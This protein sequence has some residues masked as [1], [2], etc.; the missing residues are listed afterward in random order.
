M[1]V[2]IYP[3]EVGITWTKGKQTRP[4]QR[5]VLNPAVT[6]PR[7]ILGTLGSELILSSVIMAGGEARRRVRG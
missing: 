7:M 4:T 6:V 1:Q 3:Q 5:T 2:T